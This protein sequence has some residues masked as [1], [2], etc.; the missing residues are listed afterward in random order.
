MRFPLARSSIDHEN[1]MSSSATDIVD[2]VFKFC[3][4]LSPHVEPIL[5]VISIVNVKSFRHRLDE[6]EGQF[7]VEGRIGKFRD[8]IGWRSVF[9]RRNE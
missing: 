8:K 5:F 9:G 2:V 7:G 1:V 3:K 6:R 4:L